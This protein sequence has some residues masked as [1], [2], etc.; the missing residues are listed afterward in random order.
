MPPILIT[1]AG[2]AT[3]LDNLK[4][5]KAA[6]PDGL[7]PMV[8]DDLDWLRKWEATR[9]I[10]FNNTKCEVL[11]ISR[12][13]TPIQHTYYLNGTPLREVDHGKDLARYMVLKRS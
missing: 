13:K 10:K 4:P 12:S 6:G 8:Q 11:W 5:H 2:I 7:S 9:R 1:T 3:L